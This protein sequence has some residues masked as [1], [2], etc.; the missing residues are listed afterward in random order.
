MRTS[1]LKYNDLLRKL[2]SQGFDCENSRFHDIFTV[3]F[4]DEDGSVFLEKSAW[5]LILGLAATDWSVRGRPK[6]RVIK[7]LRIQ[8]KIVER[9]F[10]Q[11]NHNVSSFLLYHPPTI[12]RQ[13]LPRRRIFTVWCE[14]Q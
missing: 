14:Y 12:L 1:S 8:V 13:L 7:S 3:K 10:S 9:G 11:Q 5:M 4:V 6:N 2:R